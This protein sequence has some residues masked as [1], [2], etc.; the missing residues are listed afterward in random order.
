[1]SAIPVSSLPA[2]SAAATFGT[3]K[4]VAKDQLSIIRDAF[5]SLSSSGLPPTDIPMASFTAAAK[6]LLPVYAL[7]FSSS[8]VVRSRVENAS[9]RARWR[10][11]PSTFTTS[12]R[13]CRCFC[14]L[15]QA[16]T[17][18]ADLIKHIKELDDALAN[19]ASSTTAPAASITIGQMIG[20]E[21]KR[22]GVGAPALKQG[23]STTHGLLWTVRTLRFIGTFMMLLE[24][25]D[26][27]LASK[28]TN[29]LGRQAYG[30]VL[31]PF[32][33]FF[34]RNIVSLAF[35]AVP[36]REALQRA[37]G[38]HDEASSR[39]ALTGAST[40]RRGSRYR[41]EG[42]RDRGGRG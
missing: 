12:C 11:R 33:G 10:T 42:G 41:W 38:F 17:L 14:C 20:E 27:T 13:C 9:S 39:A 21:L 24:S 18:Q 29:E 25:T 3:E 31:Q 32:H 2:S 40:V 22:L 16:N 28:S 36:N 5:A 1:M 23:P 7:F 30:Q 26:P 34:V 19:A 4:A 8:T 37:F 35:S 6:T 15:L